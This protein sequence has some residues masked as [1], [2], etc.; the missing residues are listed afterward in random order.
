[1]ARVE[2]HQSGALVVVA[3]TPAERRLV[4]HGVQ[5]G[6]ELV[7]LEGYYPV[8][9]DTVLLPEGISTRGARRVQLALEEAAASH[10]EAERRRQRF[11]IVKEPP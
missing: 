1:M 11:R 3:E 6:G 10:E 5:M 7:L 4:Q 2:R 8:R 9:D